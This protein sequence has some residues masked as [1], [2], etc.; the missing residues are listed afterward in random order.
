MGT[1]KNILLVAVSLCFEAT[2][3]FVTAKENGT[4]E[5]YNFWAEKNLRDTRCPL[6]SFPW[7]PQEYLSISFS[8]FQNSIKIRNDVLIY[9]C[10][11]RTRL[12]SGRRV[13]LDFL[14]M[15]ELF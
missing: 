11:P 1:A 15:K 8:L 2:K 4:Y 13:W 14:P 5:L 3:V 12:M 6:G 7:P 10:I 9:L